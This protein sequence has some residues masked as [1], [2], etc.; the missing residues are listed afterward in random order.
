MPN[1]QVTIKHVDRVGRDTCSVIYVDQD[2]NPGSRLLTRSEAER[3]ESATASGLP[4]LTADANELKLAAGAWRIR[5]AYLYDPLPH[6]ISA[7][8]EHIL[9][10]QPLRFLLADDPGAGKGWGAEARRG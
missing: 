8:Y 6:Q 2:G 1:G 4:P 9:N 3:L 5:L 7:V 10:R